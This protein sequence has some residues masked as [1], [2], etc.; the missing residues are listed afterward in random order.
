MSWLARARRRRASATATEGEPER[1]SSM[2]V[3]SC[4]SPYTFHQPDAGH[5]PAGAANIRA[6]AKLSAGL[7]A[8]AGA[9]PG[10]EAQA[11]NTAAPNK[12]TKFFIAVPDWKWK[13][14]G[15]G[16]GAR[17]RRAGG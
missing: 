11:D 2:S 14:K 13:L 17:P 10:S 6:L 12:V 1:P 8:G 16:G 15:S 5:S 9:F 4:V 3:S 7:M